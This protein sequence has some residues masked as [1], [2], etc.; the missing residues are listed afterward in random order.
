MN[1]ISLGD[2]KK[3]YKDDFV[4][5]I[6]LFIK[7]K[8]ILE[9]CISMDIPNKYKPFIEIPDD[10][11]IL[12]NDN[13]LCKT[14]DIDGSFQNTDVVVGSI[15]NVFTPMLMQI[16]IAI[17]KCNQF[18]EFIKKDIIPRL[19]AWDMQFKYIGG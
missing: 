4:F 1:N 11:W 8:L 19:K 10:S 15:I 14:I 3:I 16:D 9:V 7:D 5:S 18:N 12:I 17:D 13:I 6:E 2:F